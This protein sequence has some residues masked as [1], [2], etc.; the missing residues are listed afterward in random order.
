MTKR[1]RPVLARAVLLT[2]S[3]MVIP[4]AVSLAELQHVPNV[5]LSGLDGSV[6][7][8][9]EF[10][11]NVLLVNFW[12]TWCAPCLREIPE[13]VRLARHFEKKGLKVVGIAVNS[14]RPEDVRH[15]MA[16]HGMNYEVL[17]GDLATVKR[18]FHVVGFPTSLLIDRRGVIRK[19]YLGPQTEEALKHDIELLP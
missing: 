5:S 11:S 8:L 3:L 19:R 1:F 10:Q 7:T 15:F 9:S 12:G 4:T 14:G 2:A 6:R 13:L 17:L 18:S 16:Q